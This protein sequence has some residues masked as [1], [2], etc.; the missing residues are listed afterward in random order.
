MIQASLGLVILKLVLA[1]LSLL[2]THEQLPLK[3]HPPSLYVLQ[4]VF[5]QCVLFIWKN[6]LKVTQAQQ[7]FHLQFCR[8]VQRIDAFQ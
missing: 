4:S 2:K 6:V 1:T 5:G 8:N 3:L 7:L